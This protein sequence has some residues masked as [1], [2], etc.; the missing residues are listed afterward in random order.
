M[1]GN[2]TLYGGAGRDLLDGG[3]GSDVIDGGA[4]NDTARYHGPLASYTV[5]RS[6]GGYAVQ[7]RSGIEGSDQLTGVERLQFSDAAL[8]LDINGNAGL[9]YRL[10]QAAFDRKPDLSGLGFWIAQLDN[11]ATLTSVANSFIQSEE[12]QALYGN[13]PSNADIVTRFY[14][15]VLHRQPDPEGAKFW[16]DA[17]NNGVATTAEVL[18]GFSESTENQAALV[19]VTQNGIVYT[20]F[21]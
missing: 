17:L 21:G 1:A 4:G 3:A 11:G 9:G 7:D 20:Q 15:N 19:G 2:D 12:F 13:H 16:T 18:A 6:A 14:T 5:T 10:Y 8:A